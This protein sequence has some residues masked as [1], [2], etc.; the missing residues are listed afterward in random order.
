MNGRGKMKFW[1]SNWDSILMTM[2]VGTATHRMLNAG[3]HFDIWVV[4]DGQRHCLFFVGL[5]WKGSFA[6]FW[7]NW[8]P[9]E[10]EHQ[11][12]RPK[13][14]CVMHTRRKD[15][16]STSESKK[17]SSNRRT[18]LDDEKKQTR[19]TRRGRK[20]GLAASRKSA[21]AWNTKIRMCNAH[22][23]KRQKLDE[24]TIRNATA[25]EINESIS[26]N[27]LRYSPKFPIDGE[28]STTKRN[29]RYSVSKRHETAPEINKDGGTNKLRYSPKLP[30]TNQSNRYGE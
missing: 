10:K 12:E 18:R 25:Q 21:Q 27:K 14:G 3:V 15:K 5:F 24:Q 11:S 22:K 29:R 13:F 6:M 26:T 4:L 23:T 17:Q 20:Q 1:R 8:P 2:S 19:A 28:D 16:S 9:T 7:R 30:R